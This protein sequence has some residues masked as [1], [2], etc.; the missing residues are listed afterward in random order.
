MDSKEWPREASLSVTSLVPVSDVNF[1]CQFHSCNQKAAAINIGF[2]RGLDEWCQT[3]PTS[4][5]GSTSS[6]DITS[7]WT[8][9]AGGV[10]KGRVY[11]LGELPS[12]CHS[13]PLLSGASTSQSLEEMEAMHKKISELTERLQTSEANFAKVQKLMQNIWLNLMIPK[14]K[15][16]LM[17]SSGVPNK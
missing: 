4:E 1:P 15:A 17:K 13:S 11:E 6:T 12:L 10:N 9:V 8:N 5:T 16:T 3:Q 2:H 7:I 14:K